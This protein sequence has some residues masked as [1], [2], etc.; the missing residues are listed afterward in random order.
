MGKPYEIEQ[1]TFALR[2][3]PQLRRERIDILHVQDPQLAILVQRARKL[4]LVGTRVI[5]GHGTEEPLGFI[6]KIDYLQHLAPWHLEEARKAGV[7]KP[8]WTAIPNFIDTDR[9]TPVG[10]NLR[11]ELG[12][13]P[14]AIVVLTAAAIKRSHKRID[15]LLQEFARLRSAR[16]QVPVWL[17]AAGGWETETDELVRIGQETLGDRVRFLVRFPR[18][19]MADLYRSADLF[20]LC[21]LKEM[22]PIAL[23]EATGSG[24]PCLV[25][26]HPIMEWIVGPGGE[27]VDMAAQGALT[28]AL[29]SWI[30]S[31]QSRANSGRE[32]RQHCV[33]HFGRERV[34]EQILDYYQFVLT[35]DR[36]PASRAAA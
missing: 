15:Y 27:A 25:H 24:L 6:R 19:R 5:L 35:H 17:V 26:R 23:L 31:P 36:L 3:L 32:G 30:G 2:L 9:F 18:E 12:I 22:M 33:N 10:A 34:I 16:P 13:P 11:H 14:D 21:S 7:W 1:S 20:V 4:G 29:E 8:T 28:A